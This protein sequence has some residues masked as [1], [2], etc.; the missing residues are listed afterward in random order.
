M[1]RPD[2]VLDPNFIDFAAYADAVYSPPPALV[3]LAL[4]D[5]FWRTFGGSTS[6]PF[7]CGG[8]TFRQRAAA[9]GRREA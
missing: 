8:E 3:A 9:R 6:D 5:P 7:G 2:I 1:D 4:A